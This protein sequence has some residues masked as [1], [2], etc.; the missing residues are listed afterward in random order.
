MITKYLVETPFKQPGVLFK[1]IVS[2]ITL[3]LLFTLFIFIIIHLFNFAVITPFCTPFIDPSNSI[4]LV[5]LLVWFIVIFQ[6]LATCTTSIVYIFLFYELRKAAEK[7]HLFLKNASYVVIMIQ[8]S[9]LISANALTW[10]P[11]GIIYIFAME[12]EKYPMEIILW[13][14]ITIIPISA[15]VS[16]FV[17]ISTALR[18]I[19]T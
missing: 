2:S 9:V 13:T 6:F 17:F 19:K 8:I 14:I 3:S 15:I 4:L 7:V 11:S 1:L 5:K 10:I 18:K 16:P 12:M